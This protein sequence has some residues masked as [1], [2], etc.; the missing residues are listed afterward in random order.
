MFFAFIVKK[1]CKKAPD[2]LGKSGAG[3]GGRGRI[4]PHG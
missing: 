1:K 3:R 4:F 2:L